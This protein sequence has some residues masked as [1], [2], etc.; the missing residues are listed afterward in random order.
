MQQILKCDSVCL[1]WL[2]APQNRSQLFPIPKL[3]HRGLICKEELKYSA[4][5]Q[6]LTTKRE[7]KRWE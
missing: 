4:V 3:D 1:F 7:S 6:A 2:K 5:M